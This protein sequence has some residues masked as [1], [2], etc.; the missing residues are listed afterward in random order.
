VYAPSYSELCT[1]ATYNDGAWHHAAGTLGPDGQ[2]LYVDGNLEET[3]PSVTAS[4]FDWDTDFRAGYGYI[5]P[6]GPLTHFSGLL[7]EIRIWRIQ[8][9]EQDIAANLNQTIDPRT[10][11]LQGYWRLDGGGTTVLDATTGDH[12]GTL[13]NF[14]V[15]P[16]PWVRP[17]AL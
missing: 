13:T 15:D 11:G 5:G 14:A 3:E 4:A 9:S 1:A 7:D 10:S 17:G 16:S 12:D 8:R 6:N 2:F